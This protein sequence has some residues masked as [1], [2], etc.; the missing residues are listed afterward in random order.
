LDGK[1]VGGKEILIKL[2][3]GEGRGM[4]TPAPR[5]APPFEMACDAVYSAACG[6]FNQIF[7]L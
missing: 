6:S 3:F 2:V 4:D 5:L 1:K 7:Y